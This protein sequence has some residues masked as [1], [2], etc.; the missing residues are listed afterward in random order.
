M[1]ES[2]FATCNL[3]CKFI[4]IHHQLHHARSAA[5]VQKKMLEQKQ[6]LVAMGTYIHGLLNMPYMQQCIPS[7]FN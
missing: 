6:H 7:N 3:A 1:I 2:E 5:I 4:T